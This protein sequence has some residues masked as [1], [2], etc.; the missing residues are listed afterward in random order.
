M[1]AGCTTSLLR[2]GASPLPRVPPLAAIGRKRT[3]PVVNG[4]NALGAFVINTV[5]SLLR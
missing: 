4:G 2:V 1:S 3:W 5:A